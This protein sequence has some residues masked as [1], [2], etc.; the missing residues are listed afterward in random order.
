MCTAS[1]LAI[2][3]KERGCLEVLFTPLPCHAHGLRGPTATITTTTTLKLPSQLQ[4]QGKEERVITVPEMAESRPRLQTQ[5][6]ESELYSS[7]SSENDR[8]ELQTPPSTRLL[9]YSLPL[10]ARRASLLVTCALG[11]VFPCVT[12]ESLTPAWPHSQTV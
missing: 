7:H 3:T 11:L 6:S 10:T 1:T 8:K 12:R 5:L 2:V 4:L 9:S